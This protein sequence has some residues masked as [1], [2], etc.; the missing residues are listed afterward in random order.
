MGFDTDRMQ[1][2][3]CLPN[4]LRRIHSWRKYRLPQIGERGAARLGMPF[5]KP[6][7]GSQFFQFKVHPHRMFQ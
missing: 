6:Q 7:Y 2:A 5:D 1:G 4:K 3:G